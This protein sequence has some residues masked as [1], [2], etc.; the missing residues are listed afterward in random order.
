MSRRSS[1]DSYSDIDKKKEKRRLAWMIAQAKEREHERLKR[2]KIE[3]Y[4]RRR[5]EQLKIDRIQRSLQRCRSQSRS[6]SKSDDSHHRSRLKPK[7]NKSENTEKKLNSSSSKSLFKG[8]EEPQTIDISELQQVKVKI[9]RKIPVPANETNEIRRIVVNPEEI[10]LKRREGEGTKPIF[11]RKELINCQK[12]LEVEEHRTVEAV[13]KINTVKRSEIKR[14]SVSLS[15]RR[16]RSPSPYERSRERAHSRQSRHYSEAN[17]KR[18][19]SRRHKS[20]KDRSYSRERDYYKSKHDYTR[21]DKDIG[22]YSRSRKEHSYDR[23]ERRA[24]DS[25]RE[26]HFPSPPP[27]LPSPSQYVEQ[28]PFPIYYGGF[29]PRPMMMRPTPPMRGGPM[30]RGRFPTPIRPPF[31]PRYISPQDMYRVA[32]P[33]DPR[34]GQMY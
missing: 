23:R 14:R 7:S 19:D 10:T 4:E 20:P 33:H 32:L 34:Y 1:S 27:S 29:A 3:E 5:A 26:R 8:P 17:R 6:R 24:R 22:E 16:Q 28:V 21:S 2:K 12:P 11:D 13:G 25:S 31:P 30:M 9:H 15:P 18:D